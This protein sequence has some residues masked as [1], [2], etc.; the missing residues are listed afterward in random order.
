MQCP[1]CISEDFT[2]ID[3]DIKVDNSV[4][5]YSCRL[6]EKKWWER[7]G[8]VIELDEVLSLATVRK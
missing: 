8:D 6:C 1:R 7:N 3:I 2:E 5:F 4:R